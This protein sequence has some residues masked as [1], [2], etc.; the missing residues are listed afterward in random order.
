M[1]TTPASGRPA[2]DLE[3]PVAVQEAAIPELT[4]W[5]GAVEERLAALESHVVLSDGAV[6]TVTPVGTPPA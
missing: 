1:P 6:P 4:P 5:L 2:A 3:T